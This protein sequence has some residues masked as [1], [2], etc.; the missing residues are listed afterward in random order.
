MSEPTMPA[1]ADDG[2]HRSRLPMRHEKGVFSSPSLDAVSRQAI[3]T[4]AENLRHP[5]QAWVEAFRELPEPVGP[6]TVFE[7]GERIGRF[8]FIELGG[9]RAKLICASSSACDFDHRFITNMVERSTS[10][11]RSARVAHDPTQPCR[12]R[13]GA[14]CTYWVSW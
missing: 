9:N 7:I 1:P 13:G 5:P 3:G 11:L 12:R 14:S 6:S 2:T 10:H 4:P 8:G